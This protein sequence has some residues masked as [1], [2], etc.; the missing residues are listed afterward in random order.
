MF[1]ITEVKSWA[2]TWGYTIV[3]E[4]DDTINGASY[5]WSKNDDPSMSGVALS[6]SKVAIAIFNNLSDNKWLEHQQQYQENNK[7]EKNFSV[8][9]YGS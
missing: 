3:K 6:V 7:E 1:K 8:S 5:Y 9:D 2:K 4:K